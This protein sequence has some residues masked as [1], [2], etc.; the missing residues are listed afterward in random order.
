MPQ[1]QQMMRQ[2]YIDVAWIYGA[3]EKRGPPA[4]SPE[5]DASGGTG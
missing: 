2:K 1:D 3:W 4:R 5:F